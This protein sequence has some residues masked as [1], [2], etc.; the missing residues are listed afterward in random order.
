MC[1][2]LDQNHTAEEYLQALEWLAKNSSSSPGRFNAPPGTDRAIFHYWNGQLNAED[3]H[4]GYKAPWADSKKEYSNARRDKLL[5]GYW[6]GLLKKCRGVIAVDGWYE[7]TGEKPNKQAWHIHRKDRQP[8]LLAALTTIDPAKDT[9]HKAFTIITDDAL[10]GM[11]DVHDRRPVALNP[12]DAQTW[13]MDTFTPEEANDFILNRA[14]GPEFF[15][16]YEV[17]KAVG[18]SKNESPMFA[19]RLRKDE[20][21]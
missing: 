8:I 6:K 21:F 19:N 16:W 17:D 15:E 14:L 2:R 20:L 1:G 10:G 7:W 13:M 12:E 5:G 11:V 3:V 9:E 18:N 4:W